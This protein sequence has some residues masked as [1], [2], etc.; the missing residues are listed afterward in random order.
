VVTLDPSILVL[1]ISA[2]SASF[3]LLVQVGLE[4]E[5]VAVDFGDSI[6]LGLVVASE[7]TDKFGISCAFL[8]LL[9]MLALLSKI[10]SGLLHRQVFSDWL[11]FANLGLQDLLR[12]AGHDGAGGLDEL[13]LIQIYFGLSALVALVLLQIL[14]QVVH[15]GP[16]GL[17]SLKS[18]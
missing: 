12:L 9:L 6:C 3:L 11:A 10:L 2:E 8:C 7:V 15:S 14:N 1:R 13:G 4:H 5:G 16:T 18:T 17:L